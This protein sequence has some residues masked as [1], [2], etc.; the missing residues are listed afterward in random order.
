MESVEGG[1]WPFKRSV[2]HRAKVATANAYVKGAGGAKYR[3]TESGRQVLTPRPT[4]TPAQLHFE[5]S[6]PLHITG[7]YID[8]VVELGDGVSIGEQDIDDRC[9]AW[10]PPG[11][12]AA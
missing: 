4:T 7:V 3:L 8:P 9:E 1:G 12:E 2:R 10:E 5:N 11:P 6:T